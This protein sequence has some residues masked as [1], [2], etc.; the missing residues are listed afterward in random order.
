MPIWDTSAM[1]WGLSRYTMVLDPRYFILIHTF[2]FICF[3]LIIYLELSTDFYTLWFLFHCQYNSKCF[4]LSPC[5][6]VLRY[7]ISLQILEDFF[8]WFV[9]SL[10]PSWVITYFMWF[11]FFQICSDV[12]IAQNIISHGNCFMQAWKEC[13]LCYCW[14]NYSMNVN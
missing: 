12:F 8:L 1:D 9:S 6:V 4:K 13:F 5:T 14:T 11:P 7:V 3:H 2:Y 10:I